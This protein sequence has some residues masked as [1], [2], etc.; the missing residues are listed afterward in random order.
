MDFKVI[1]LIG[2]LSKNKLYCELL[3]DICNLPVLASENNE[4]VL[5]GSSILGAA[6]CERFK[7]VCF[8]DLI[9]RFSNIGDVNVILP[10][11]TNQKYHEK[12]YKVFLKLLEHQKEYTD[13]MD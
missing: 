8:S 11:T 5:L 10:K 6:N 13:I 7:N 4:H 2:G 12:K 3:S 1:T 9:D